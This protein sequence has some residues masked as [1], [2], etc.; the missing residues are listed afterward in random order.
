MVILNKTPLTLAEVQEHV[1]KLEEKKALEG[2][3][4][5]FI[6]LKKDKADA[7]IEELRGLNNLKMK[8]SHMAKVADFLPQDTEDI[9]K[10]FN[11]VSLSEEE[12]NAI[13]EIVKKY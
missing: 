9:N 4:K 12:S 7:L 5:K 10:I 8:E 11:D 2:Y 6:K 1:K 13:L 3:L